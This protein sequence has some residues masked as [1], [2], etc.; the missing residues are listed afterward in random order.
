[1]VP[2]LPGEG[3]HDAVEI[4]EAGVNRREPVAVGRE[5]TGRHLEGLGVTVDAEDAQLTELGQQVGGM[6]PEPEDPVHDHGDAAVLRGR[7][8]DGP[9]EL[10]GPL[11]EDGYVPGARGVAVGVGLVCHLA[12]SRPEVVGAPVVVEP[13]GPRPVP[14][15]RWGST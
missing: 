5:A 9:E 7:L 1:L 2:G 15:W 12:S 10:D 6:P 11:E 13:P 3:R 4:V 8:D 14:T